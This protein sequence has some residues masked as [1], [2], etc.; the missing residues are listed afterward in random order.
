MKKLYSNIGD[1]VCK[2]AVFCGCIGVACVIIGLFC[3]LIAFTAG[4]D[5]LL[6]LGPAVAVLGVICLI[7]SWPLYAFGQ[8][9]NDVHAMRNSAPAKATAVQFSDLP[10]L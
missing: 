10:E 1:K 8:I 2:V 6:I 4:E 7:S 9:T 3:L 5:V